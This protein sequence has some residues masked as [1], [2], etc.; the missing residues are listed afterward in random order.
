MCNH[1]HAQTRSQHA[2]QIASANLHVMPL[3]HS[4]NGTGDGVGLDDITGARDTLKLP[5][6]PLK[7]LPCVHPH[8][9]HTTHTRIHIH[10]HP[11][12]HPH[13]HTG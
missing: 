8:I 1:V 7:E 4:A 12:T 13:T 5:L 6:L 11:H 10:T 3:P 9:T 2:Q